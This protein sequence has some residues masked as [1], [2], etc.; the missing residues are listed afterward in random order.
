MHIV[1]YGGREE[2]RERDRKIESDRALHHTKSNKLIQWLI[3]KKNQAHTTVLKT[4]L[5]FK[6]QNWK[7]K[8]KI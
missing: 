6:K 2:E 5:K 7:T 3:N 8:L 1:V 4:N